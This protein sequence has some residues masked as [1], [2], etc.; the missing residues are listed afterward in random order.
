MPGLMPE[1][2]D[3]PCEN[4]STLLVS[5]LAPVA[6]LLKHKGV[7]KEVVWNRAWAADLASAM[8]AGQWTQARKAAVPHFQVESN[9]CQLCKE[10]VG[11]LLHRF[12]C[13]ATMP[14]G[15][16]PRVPEQ[17]WKALGKL[18]NRRLEVL[19]TRGFLVAKVPAPVRT[20]EWFTWLLQL[21]DDDPDDVWYVD[22]SL[23]DAKFADFASAG[24]SVVVLAR[25]GTLKAYGHGA[26]PAWCRTAAAAETWAVSMALIHAVIIPH[27]RTDCKSILATARIPELC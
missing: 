23:F 21:S 27:V 25:N 13:S 24:F 7:A 14:D 8:S 9:L 18:S 4:G 5:F 12:E 19:A 1:D 20:G 10:Q 16:W 22:G 3:L 26:P 15:G 6:A 2:P 11:T 17:G